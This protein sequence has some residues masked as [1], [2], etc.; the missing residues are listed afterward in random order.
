MVRFFA[1]ASD[2]GDGIIQL[3]AETA[4]H[5]RSLRLRPSE[6]F[7]VCDGDGTDYI[8]R[9]GE[10]GGELSAEIIEAFPSRGEPSVECTVYVALAK[11]D[12]LEYAVQKSVELGARRIALFPSARVVAGLGD[13]SKKTAR[14]QRIALEAAKQSFRG[15]VPDVTAAATFAEAVAEAALA[16][17]PIFFYECEEEQHLK[18]ILESSGAFKSVSIMT[19]PEGGYTEDEAN[20]AKSAGLSSATLGPRLLRCET[21][22]LAALSAIMFHTGN[23]Q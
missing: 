8:C 19:G 11:G 21:A 9:L 13:I 14:L 4:Q 10:R 12:R 18:Q 6:R 22:P 20:L 17:L 16:D 2:I 15:C 3:G 1:A 7:T 23:M 5:V